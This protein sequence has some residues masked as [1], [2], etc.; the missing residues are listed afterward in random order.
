MVTY[1][2]LRIYCLLEVK[3]LAGAKHRPSRRCG[4]ED[5]ALF[6]HTHTAADIVHVAK[7]TFVLCVIR[8]IRASRRP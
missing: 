7:I 4:G 6:T 3:E 2:E 1:D 5:N 8:L